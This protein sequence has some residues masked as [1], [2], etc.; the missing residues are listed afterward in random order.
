MAEEWPIA[1]LFDEDYLHFYGA[2]LADDA[3]DGE[4][5]RVSAGWL[6]RLGPG[7]RTWPHRQQAG[8]RG[9]SG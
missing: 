8:R 2:R 9:C 6:Q 7:L 1:E 5:S 4:A 3:S